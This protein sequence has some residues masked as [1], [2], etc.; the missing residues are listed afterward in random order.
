MNIAHDPAVQ[1]LLTL[2]LEEDLPKGDVTT[3]GCISAETR[4]KGAFI[5]RDPCV[6]AGLDVGAA[7]FERFRGATF[8]P[9]VKEGT[10]VEAR[11][12]IAYVE[13]SAQSLLSGERTALNFM[14]RLC[15]VATQAKRFVDA[16]AHTS[17]RV[18]DT[19]KTTPGWR[20]LEKYAAQLGGAKNHRADL[21]SGVL[22]KDNHIV[23]AGSITAAIQRSR[24]HAS[25]LLK[26]ECEVVD[27]KGLI[28]AIN[29]GADIILLDNMKPEQIREAVKLAEEHKK[30]PQRVLLEASGG[31]N[32]Q[33]IAS[34]AEAGADIIS[35][36]AIT[37]SAKA[38]DIGLDFVE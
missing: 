24:A 9:L 21:S 28:E 31:I 1:A 3:E 33:T 27:L 7:V 36:G 18:V 32:L 35:A 6:V 15:G 22:I 17:C 4:S 25:H 37:H 8:T 12:T 30:G 26:V 14:Q 11:T 2:A 16:V 29:A 19:R 10:W 34:Y 38:I 20:R 23:A 13:G 5:T